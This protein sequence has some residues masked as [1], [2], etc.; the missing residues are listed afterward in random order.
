LVDTG[1]Y[2][3]FGFREWKRFGGVVGLLGTGNV[4]VGELEDTAIDDNGRGQRARKRHESSPSGMRAQSESGGRWCHVC[5]LES[6][7]KLRL[8]VAFLAVPNGH[9][10]AHSHESHRWNKQD[11]H[12]AVDGV[13]AVFTGS[14]GGAV[15]HRAALGEGGASP[16][17][18]K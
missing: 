17:H 10:D 7:F 2:Q 15:T 16:E 6:G 11:Q 9:A 14:G 12:S 3:Y 1:F 5:L 18:D 4:R 8:L 13:L